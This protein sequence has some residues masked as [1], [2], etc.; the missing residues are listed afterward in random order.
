MWEAWI[1]FWKLQEI[2]EELEPGSKGFNLSFKKLTIA[3]IWKILYRR[4]RVEPG[5]CIDGILD[6]SCEEGET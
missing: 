4:S 3:A 2:I 5:R 6:Y 1:L